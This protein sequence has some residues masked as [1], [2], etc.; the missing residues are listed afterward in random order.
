MNYI[1]EHIH[2]ILLIFWIAMIPVTVIWL[3]E[4]VLW[5]AIMS[6]YANIESSAAAREARKGSEGNQANDKQGYY[7]QHDI[8]ASRKR[9]IRIISRC[10]G[11]FPR[12]ISSTR[13]RR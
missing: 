10:C 9:C 4:S 11:I 8:R 7:I 5:I 12:K 3:K 1:K 6:L 2:T 13:Y